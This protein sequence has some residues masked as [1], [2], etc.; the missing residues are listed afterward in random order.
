MSKILQIARREFVATVF[1]K[2]FIIGL[3]M[4]P[5]VIAVGVLVG[6]WLFVDRDVAVHGQVALIDPTGKVAPELRDALTRGRA[7]EPIGQTR[8]TVAIGAAPKLTLVDRPADTDI[9]QEKRWLG[10]A[11]TESP[12]LA[13]AVIHADAIEP[14]AGDTTFGSYDFL[15][16]PKRNIR[17]ETTI[18]QSL[19]E[20]IVNAR[21]RARGLDRAEINDLVTVPRVQPVTVSEDGERG[22]GGAF[23]FLLPFTFMMLLLMGVMGS[24]QGLLTTTIEEKSS[25]VIEVLLSAVSPMQLMAGK[26]LG[27]MGISLIGISLYSISVSACSR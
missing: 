15:V 4:L 5:A 9:E 18:E 3:L 20:A 16:P 1:T 25:R 19:R 10:V 13:V 8:A 24:G 26:L 27:H 6:S 11:D 12:H 17:A 22:N 21:V 2:T 7:A 14:R 23:N